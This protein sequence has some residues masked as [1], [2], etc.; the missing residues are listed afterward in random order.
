MKSLSRITLSRPQFVVMLVGLAAVVFA[1]VFAITSSYEFAGLYLR[2][3]WGPTLQREFGFTVEERAFP[4]G[5]G[6]TE[7]YL[8]IA[9]TVPGGLLDRSGVVP[10]DAP[11]DCHHGCTSGFYGA[12]MA[13]RQGPGVRLH[14]LGSSDLAQDQGSV[15][16]VMIVSPGERA[17]P[18]Q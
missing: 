7:Y 6:T 13:A 2:Y 1:G 5:G 3:V 9:S 17:K 11:L 15:R 4:R 10:D 8:V 12:L 16:E 18:V 14:V